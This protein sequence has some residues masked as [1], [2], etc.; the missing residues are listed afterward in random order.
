[1]GLGCE[2]HDRGYMIVREDGIQE[3]GITDRALDKNNAGVRGLTGIATTRQVSPG[4]LSVSLKGAVD[5][6]KTRKVLQIARVRQGIKD[7]QTVL[8]MLLKLEA[9]EVGA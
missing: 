2:M 9:H 5:D 1:M 6:V 4:S 7:H 3:R 8:G